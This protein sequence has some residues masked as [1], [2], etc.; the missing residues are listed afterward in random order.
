MV[1]QF[2]LLEA[3]C[4]K[5]TR[6]NIFIDQHQDHDYEVLHTCERHHQLLCLVNSSQECLCFDGAVLLS[7]PK[8]DFKYGTTGRQCH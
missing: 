1:V 3:A 2:I 6:Q 4:V 8:K 7:N 5:L